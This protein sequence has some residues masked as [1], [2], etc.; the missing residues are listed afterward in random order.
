MSEALFNLISGL[1]ISLFVGMNTNSFLPA[2]TQI[3]EY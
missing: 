2:G 3:Q 1:F